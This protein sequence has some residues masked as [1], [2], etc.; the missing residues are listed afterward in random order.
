[1][2]RIWRGMI[3]RQDIIIQIESITFEFKADG[4]SFRI[5]EILKNHR[6]GMSFWQYSI[7]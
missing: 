7:N 1:M 5:D 4:A 3:A 6:R 2:W